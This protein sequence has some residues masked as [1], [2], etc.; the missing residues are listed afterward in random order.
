MSGEKNYWSKDVETKWHPPEGFFEQPAEKIARGLKDA[1]QDLAQAM[2][3][4]DFFLNRAGSKL[5][6]R[7]RQRLEGVKPILRGLF[8]KD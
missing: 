7:E 8:G 3:R 4:L 5:P 1:S 2:D 6:P